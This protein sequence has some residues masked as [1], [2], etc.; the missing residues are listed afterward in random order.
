MDKIQLLDQLPEWYKNVL[1]FREVCRTE[2]EEFDAIFQA[3]HEVRDNFFFQTMDIASVAQWESVM[4][5]IPNPSSETLEFRRARLLNRLSNRPPFTLEFLKQKLDVLIGAGAWNIH[6]DYPNYT[7]YVES[8]AENQTYATEVA[9]TIQTTAPAHMVFCNSPVTSATLLLAEGIEQT[10]FTYHYQLGRWNLGQKPF[11]TTQKE[12]LKL[13]DVP[14]LKPELIHRTASFLMEHIVSARINGSILVSEIEKTIR[15]GEVVVSYT[16]LPAHTPNVTQ[17][18]L[19]GADGTILS[20]I[21]V[22]IPVSVMTRV[23][24][25]LTAEEGVN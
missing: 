11:A 14:S 2:Q 4:K 5:I 22:Y 21:R 17:L 10:V 24:H 1:D 25:T 6:V 23:K 3:I 19:L 12:G 7:L 18:E 20:S 16:I 8:N 9:F 15:G 13:P